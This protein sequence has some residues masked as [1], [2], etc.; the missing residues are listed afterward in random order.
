M[1]QCLVNVSISPFNIFLSNLSAE[2]KHVTASSIVAFLTPS[3]EYS[4]SDHHVLN[5]FFEDEPLKDSRIVIDR[6]SQTSLHS[7]I[8]A[9][10]NPLLDSLDLNSDELNTDQSFKLRQL[11]S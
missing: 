8:P 6:N 10:S 1:A 2:P 7:T 5:G 9:N 3:I 4:A 11:V